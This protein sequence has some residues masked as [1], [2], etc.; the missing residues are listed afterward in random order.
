MSR[1]RG[2]PIG[3]HIPVM[4][5]QVIEALKVQSAKTMVDCTVGYGGHAM[6][7]LKAM[8]PDSLFIGLD[9]DGANLQRTQVR[10]SRFGQR[11]KLA[12][13]NFAQLPDVLA[14]LRIEKVDVIFADL[15]P[16]S[17]QIDDPARGF[18]Y[19]HRDCPLDMRM[20]DRLTVTGA[21]LLATLS[22]QQLEKALWELSDEPDCQRIAEF[23]V[24]QRQVRPITTTSELVRIVFAAKGTTEKAWEKHRNFDDPHPAARTFQTLRILVN[25]E[26]DNLKRLLTAAPS[27]LNPGGR[28]GV[29]SFHRGEDRIVKQAFKDG[30]EQGL[31]S[32]VSKKATRPNINE[33]R[34][35][36]RSSSA[37]LRWAVRL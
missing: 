21:Q 22:Q 6:A 11:V 26:L 20:D 4:V 25:N 29:M 28:I 12:R 33:I 34:S 35:N 37:M 15:G 7:L 17:M 8:R 10:L 14:E 24:A 31:Y 5:D 23:I 32:W 2:T 30:L 3:T 27:L 18:S 36:P 13:G 1:R 9:V 16:S 19:K